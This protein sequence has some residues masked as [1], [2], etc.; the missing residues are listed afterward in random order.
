MIF[1]LLIVT[2]S[3]SLYS[4][5]PYSI[6]IKPNSDT[7]SLRRILIANTF[8]Q[9]RQFYCL[10]NTL[11]NSNH[12]SHLQ[13][14]PRSTFLYSRKFPQERRLEEQS[15]KINALELENQELK[16]KDATL[17]QKLEELHQKL[18]NLSEAPHGLKAV[19]SHYKD[20]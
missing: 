1:F 9:T 18:N 12:I 2:T 13:Q 10:G 20:Y 3:C 15:K 5:N 19:A 4:K 7:I 11:L 8:Q 17:Q 14:K 16:T 6:H